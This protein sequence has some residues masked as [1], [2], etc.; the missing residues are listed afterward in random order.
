LPASAVVA[1]FPFGDKAWELRYLYFAALHRRTLVNGYSGWFPPGYVHRVAALSQLPLEPD[2]AWQALMEARPTHV[3][4]HGRSFAD[5]DRAGVIAAWLLAHG[6][7]F[8]RAFGD[9]D[10]IY[11]MPPPQ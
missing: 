4:L 2:T 10:V 6:A 7:T 8:D 11:T 5:P 1:E 3:V 9:G